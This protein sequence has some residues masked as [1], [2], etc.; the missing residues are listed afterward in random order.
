LGRLRT[1]G[2]AATLHYLPVH[3]QPYYLR[4]GFQA[5][6]FPEAERYSREAVTLPLYYDL[7]LDDQDRVVREL[8]RALEV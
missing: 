4:L 7:S 3:T 2:I 6:D 5:G 1:A 8:A